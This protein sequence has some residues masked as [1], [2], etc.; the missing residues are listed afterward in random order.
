MTN[1]SFRAI[2]GCKIDNQLTVNIAQEPKA[3]SAE[4]ERFQTARDRKANDT[5]TG[6]FY[7]ASLANPQPDGVIELAAELEYTDVDVVSNRKKCAELFNLPNMTRWC[8]PTL[9]DVSQLTNYYKQL[10][11]DAAFENGWDFP[12]AIYIDAIDVDGTI[13]IGPQ[14]QAAKV[15]CTDF[16]WSSCSTKA[17]CGS[18]YEPNGETEHLDAHDSDGTKHSFCALPWEAH[19][20]CCAKAKNPTGKFG[21]VDTLIA[22]NL[23]KGCTSKD[24]IPASCSQ[25]QALVASRR[26]NYPKLVWDE[27]SSG[28]LS[29]WPSL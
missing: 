8:P 3:A 2:D 6:K 7:L 25:L 20:K 18:G 23:R 16:K 26:A 5:E 21:Y 11:I 9:L 14:S 4:M 22:H 15:A 28:R 10:T 19:Y 12:N 1:S 27:Y 29:T 24:S 13:R 17:S